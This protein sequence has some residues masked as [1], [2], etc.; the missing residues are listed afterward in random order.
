MR[1]PVFNNSAKEVSKTYLAAFN[2]PIFAG[3][4]LDATGCGNEDHVTYFPAQIK[5]YVKLA[6]KYK[7]KERMILGKGVKTFND[8]AKVKYLPP[9]LSLPVRTIVYGDKVAITDFKDP[10]MLIMIEKKS[11]AEAYMNYFN[12]LWKIAKP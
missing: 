9:E 12:A 7:I 1:L 4:Q 10:M 3:E 6:K 5:E 8:N 11:V 2:S